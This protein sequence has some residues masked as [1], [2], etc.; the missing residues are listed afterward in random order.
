MQYFT[1]PK[2]LLL[3]CILNIFC[4]CFSSR[5]SSIPLVRDMGCQI[6]TRYRYRLVSIY[7]GDK[8]GDSDAKQKS[9]EKCYPGVFSDDGTPFAVRC[10]SGNYQSKYG[11]SLF[12]SI[13]SGFIIPE[14]HRYEREFSFEIEMSNDNS[15]RL[16]FKV[17]CTQEG[18][19]SPMPTGLIP[20]TGEP[21]GDGRRVFWRGEKKIG[22]EPELGYIWGLSFSLEDQIAGQAF[23]YAVAVKLKELEDEGKIDAMLQKRE[24]AKSKAPAHKVMRF[25]RESGNDFTYGFTL[26]LAEIPSNPDA[27][28]SAVINEFGE[29]VKEEYID[30]F[31]RAKKESLAV[32]Y[33][34]IRVDG[35]T[36]HG[37]ATVLTI[38]PI[39]LI[40]DANTR[41]G[42]LSVRFNA[43]QVEEARAWIRKNIETLARDKNIAL[44]TGTLPPEATYYSL[45][46]K[47]D[48]NVMEIEFK[49]E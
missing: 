21:N 25:A 28:V 12:F 37:R 31:P 5:I 41:R 17:V 27:A 39:S 49:T 48:G 18:G 33:E 22:D 24:A 42:K 47:I 30:S 8:S 3:T 29:S 38:V 45:G 13:C 2:F 4:G 20:F 10:I 1:L 15:V 6:T 35:K 32:N 7:S 44:T 23:A 43:G 36:I 40:Y 16:P 9:L 14:F 11:W 26:E 19:G 34:D 46:E